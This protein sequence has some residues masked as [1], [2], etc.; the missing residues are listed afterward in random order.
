VARDTK[1]LSGWG[2]KYFDYDNDGT[3][4]LLLANGHP[5]DMIDSYSMQVKYKEPLVLYQQSKDGKFHNI[6]QTAGPV[7]QK[8]FAARGLAVGDYDND[9]A[10]DVL[11]GVN[12]GPPVLLGNGA[13]R[14]NNWL[15]LKLEGV[16]CN[17]DAIGA[18]IVWKAAG[19]VS[20]RLK[21]NGGSYLSSHDP[22]EVLGIGAATHIDELEI[23]WPAPSKH[24]EKLNNLAPNRYIHLVEGK[25]IV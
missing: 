19:K 6:S 5:D 4:D 2:L 18:R 3:V 9:G 20:A 14:G 11:I 17:R 16:T 22:R 23:H 25:G 13:A 21:N 8:Q 12:G 15:G 7:F 10:L 1:L 24:I